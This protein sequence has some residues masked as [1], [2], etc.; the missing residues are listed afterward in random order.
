MN[1]AQQILARNSDPAV[2]TGRLNVQD[3]VSARKAEIERLE[4]SLGAA[5]TQGKKRAFQTVPR[6]LRRRTASHNPERVPKR[7]RKRAR[8]EASQDAAV[9]P[10]RKPDHGRLEQTPRLTDLTG[11]GAK[12]ARPLGLRYSKRQK[13]VTW[14]PTHIWHTKRAHL[15][16]LW[17]YKVPTRPT[18]KFY[19]ATHRIS[20]ELEAGMAWDT[21]YFATI[22][23]EGDRERLKEK[24]TQTFANA[25]KPIFTNGTK[26]WQGQIEEGPVLLYW[27]PNC[28]V[29]HVHPELFDTIWDLFADF[30]KQDCRYSI[31]SIEVLGKRALST[32]VASLRLHKSCEKSI[33]TAW[34]SLALVGSVESLPRHSV[35]NLNICDPRGYIA[36]KQRPKG[37]VEKAVDT[38]ESWPT[39]TAPL[40]D[41]EARRA[42][43]DGQQTLEEVNKQR[44]AG[45][46]LTISDPAIPVTLVALDGGRIRMLLPWAWVNPVWMSLMH[47]QLSVGGLKQQEQIAFERGVCSFP[48]DYPLTAAGQAWATVDR[49]AKYDAYFRR[50]AAKRVSYKQELG[51]AFTC[52][53]SL[54][55][56]QALNVTPVVVRTVRRGAPQDGARI[57][58]LPPDDYQEWLRTVN[59]EV[60]PD[61]QPATPGPE[62]LMG[63]VTSGNFNLQTGTG[64]GVGSCVQNKGWCLVRNVGQSFCRLAKLEPAKMY[65]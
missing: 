51:D 65:F 36:H 42:A 55:G 33:E 53:W 15:E 58:A 21:S 10:R 35:L 2:V 38:L 54:L 61:A 59:Q 5:A 12:A 26:I 49:K 37:T 40:F 18:L 13:S 47:S 56:D 1:R 23:I 62:F 25:T 34:K 30:E 50:P 14:L 24:V 57:Y 64:T 52:D 39:S 32:L 22:V 27:Q 45:E 48:R 20:D 3:F 6:R 31:G 8:K 44:T 41:I 17:G 60:A 28:L 43:V 19:R 9:A 46:T 7:L 4:A 16:S 29:A 11:I 63:F